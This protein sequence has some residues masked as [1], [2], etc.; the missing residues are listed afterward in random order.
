MEGTELTCQD[1][2]PTFDQND[3]NHLINHKLCL[4]TAHDSMA[5]TVCD[6]RFWC[7]F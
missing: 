6:G 4:D 7:M 1:T 2:M 3:Q 5:K